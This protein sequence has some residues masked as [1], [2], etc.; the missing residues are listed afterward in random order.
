LK[1]RGWV[2][3]L[4]EE[5]DSSKKFNNGKK[6]KK[7]LLGKISCRNQT[8]VEKITENNLLEN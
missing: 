5:N 4:L 3:F 7:I 6:I 8:N 2:Y 1:T